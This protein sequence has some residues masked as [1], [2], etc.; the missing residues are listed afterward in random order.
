MSK[1]SENPGEQAEIITQLRHICEI[2]LLGFAF[3]F[4]LAGIIVH[5]VGARG[6]LS[7]WF[8]LPSAIFFLLFLRSW[9]SR[10]FRHTALYHALNNPSA[11]ATRN[12]SPEPDPQV[13]PTTRERPN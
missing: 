12:P 10:V 1:P 13:L 2:L 3:M 4:L 7:F 8:F 6:E 5:Q 11:V 9:W